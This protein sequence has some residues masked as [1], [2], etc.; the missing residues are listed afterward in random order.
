MKLL[1][2]VFIAT[3]CLLKSYGQNWPLSSSVWHQNGAW[4]S[5][6]NPLSKVYT[7]SVIDSMNYSGY[8]CRQVANDGGTNFLICNDGSPQL[9]YSRGA[10]VYPFLNFSDEVG[11]TVNHLVHFIGPGVDEIE[12]IS[13]VISSY[14]SNQVTVKRLTTIDD[15]L[16]ENQYEGFPKT[17]YDYVD[18]VGFIGHAFP[19]PT[20]SSYTPFANFNP[21]FLRCYT[22]DNS[23]WQS[24][25][26]ASYNKPCDFLSDTYLSVGSHS[27]QAITLYPNP[28]Q[29][30]FKVLGLTGPMSASVFA[31]D[32]R[33]IGNAQ[34][35][36]GEF[37]FTWLPGGFYIVTIGNEFKSATFKLLM[38]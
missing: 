33:W 19:I 38:E 5:P 22:D 4:T 35:E 14:V 12:V 13:S 36:T 8:S 29:K 9:Y 21:E 24:L 28:A 2:T 7:Y 18:G 15:E 23:F 3:F 11:D 1:C 27:D 17:T 25:L 31:T 37:V 20:S 16:F 10:A 30:E 6:E 34:S 26:F 32:G